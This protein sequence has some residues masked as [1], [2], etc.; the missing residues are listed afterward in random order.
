MILVIDNYDSFT[1]NLVQYL[2]MLG[3]EI[4]VVRND[5][6][7]LEDIER[8]NPRAIL[9]SPGPGNPDQAG[10]CLEVVQRFYKELPILGVCLGHQ[11]IAQ[12]FGGEIVKAERPMH[13]KVSMIRHDRKS[14]FAKIKDSLAVARYHSLVV[15]LES[16]PDCLEVSATAENG[17][18]MALRHKHYQV[19]SLQFHPESIMTE[20]G[21]DLLENFFSSTSNRTR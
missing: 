9:L 2:E 18:I 19:E 7:E 10:I 20:Q 14:I 15:E 3:E 13:G 1:F 16:M 12:A 21:L 5:Q 11:V 6:C 17:E 8:L 4:M